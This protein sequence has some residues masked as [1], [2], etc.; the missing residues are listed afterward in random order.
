MSDFNI[1]NLF[2]GGDNVE[3]KKSNTSKR[4]KWRK[5]KSNKKKDDSS[6]TSTAKTSESVDTNNDMKELRRRFPRSTKAERERYLTNAHLIRAT[7]RMDNYLEWRQRMKFDTKDFKK[8]RSNLT[9][10]KETWNFA[11]S[12]TAELCNQEE[13][14]LPNKG[15]ISLP[16]IIKFGDSKKDFRASDKR[17][18]AQVLPGLIDK[19]IAP[20]SF[21]AQCVATYLELKFD[22]KKND[23]I[24]VH[25]DVRQGVNWPNLTPLTLIPFTTELAGLLTDYMPNRLY[26]IYVYPLPT[27]ASPVWS[28]YK[29][30]IG[31]EYANKVEV[32]WGESTLADAELPDGLE[33]GVFRGQ[34][35]RDLEQ[36]RYDEFIIDGAKK[37]ET[38]KNKNST[39]VGKSK[40]RG[41]FQRKKKGSSETNETAIVEQKTMSSSM[42]AMVVG[43]FMVLGLLSVNKASSQEIEEPA[44]GKR[45]RSFFRKKQEKITNEESSDEEVKENQSSSVD[46]VKT[47]A[48]GFLVT[49]GLLGMKTCYDC[50]QPKIEGQVVDAVPNIDD[51]KKKDNEREKKK[52]LFGRKKNSVP[53]LTGSGS[54]SDFG[55]I[56]AF[57]N[58]DSDTALTD[59]PLSPRNEKKFFARS[60][61]KAFTNTFEDPYS[62][63]DPF[64]QYGK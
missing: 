29:A 54:S 25:V 44:E 53:S 4:R 58:N 51:D 62:F 17:R 36:S 46:M 3:E 33:D 60:P 19:N 18:V 38:I 10:D 49:I 6:S 12:H 23:D 42:K 27:V 56:Y 45:K 35:L 48:Y 11:V 20:L 52:G 55:Y 24:H 31:S 16:R 14:N 41:L 32:F 57:H 47:M 64:L 28:M 63:D 39:P 2:M 30:L 37:E 22:R 7:E 15:S 34:L 13:L 1:S 5:S 59:P 21:Y 61:K 8:E 26:K 43:L 9:S 50:N 40:K